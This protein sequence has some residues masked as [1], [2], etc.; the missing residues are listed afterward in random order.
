MTTPLFPRRARWSRLSPN[1]IIPAS[2]P[3]PSRSSTCGRTTSCASGRRMTGKSGARFRLL[4]RLMRFGATYFSRSAAI[5]DILFTRA[6]REITACGCWRR[7]TSSALAGQTRS[8]TSNPPAAT[9]AGWTI[10]ARRNDVLYA[11]HNV[12]L[13]S[14]PA[15]LTGTTVNGLRYGV[16]CGRFWQHARGLIEGYAACVKFLGEH[17]PVDSSTYRLSRLL[18]K[19]GNV[20]LLE[21]EARL[22]AIQTV[23]RLALPALSASGDTCLQSPFVAETRDRR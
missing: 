4:A 20:P 17:R 15:H 11:W 18:K 13:W 12:P 9:F 2:A 6:K 21:I 8:T 1:S 3:W 10:T 23:A 7:V 22:P 14:L 16:K 19:R 5:G